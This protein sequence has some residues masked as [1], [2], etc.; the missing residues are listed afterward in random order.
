MPDGRAGI[1]AKFDDLRLGDPVILTL[2][3]AQQRYSIISI[4]TVKPDDLSVIYPTDTDRITLIT[5]D[6]YDF[7]QNTYQDRLVVV[8][9]RVT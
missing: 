3:D 7:L 5:C 8:A 2:D 4:T 1:F 6:S 9:D